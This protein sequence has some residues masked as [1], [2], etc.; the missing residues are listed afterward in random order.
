[1][2]AGTHA[3]SQ[4]KAWRKEK[5]LALL[6]RLKVTRGKRGDERTYASLST[7]RYSS[8]KICRTGRTGPRKGLWISLVLSD[9]SLPNL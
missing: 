1:M 8:R 4:A 3:F 2:Q 5:D 7:E 9:I 6:S